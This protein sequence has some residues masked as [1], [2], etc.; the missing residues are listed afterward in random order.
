MMFNRFSLY[1]KLAASLF[2]IFG[3]MI[4]LIVSW[5][6]TLEQ[7]SQHQAQQKL[8]LQLAEHLVADNPLLKKGVYDYSALENLFHTLMLLGP[9]FEFYFVDPSGEILT[10]SAPKGKVKRKNIDL[11]PLLSLIEHNNKLPIYGQDPRN[12]A[13]QKIFSVAPVYSHEKQ[14]QKHLQGYLYIIIGGEAYDTIFSRIKASGSLTLTAIWFAAGLVLLLLLLLALFRTFTQPIQTLAHQLKQIEAAQFDL[15]AI[16]LTPWPTHT[17]N[18]IH[19]LGG[20]VNQMLERIDN[21]LKQLKQNDAQRRELLAHLSHDLRTPL[22]SLQGYLELLNQAM[23][24][25]ACAQQA[26]YLAVSL[27]NAKQLKNLIDQIFE[28]AHLE[29]GQVAINTERFNLGELIYDC[30]AKFAL[31]AEQAGVTLK[32]EPQI[33]DFMILS[34]I[35]KLERVL[36]NL[37]DNALRHTPSGGTITLKVVAQG[38]KVKLQVCDTGSGIKA[39]EIDYIFDARYRASNAQGCKKT[40]GGLGLAICKQLV[41]L[42]HSD[43]QVYSQLGKGTEFEMMLLRS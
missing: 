27:N 15:S 43:I 10:Y 1:Q 36:S 38:K 5:S 30:L 4:V 22:S 8:H 14:Q 20:S 31:K 18:E 29:S 13:K 11:V 2:V 35:A 9:A 32:V 12:L 33:C 21:Q 16:T 26:E 37:I 41:K 28:L 34:D 19:Q 23:P 42:L 40:H 3:A 39:E 6:Q 17:H 7:I 24:S 25:D